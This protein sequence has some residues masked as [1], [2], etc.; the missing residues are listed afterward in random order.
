MQYKG[1]SAYITRTHTYIYTVYI[2]IYIRYTYI[3]MSTGYCI[4]P[5]HFRK[6]SSVQHGYHRGTEANII[7]FSGKK[8]NGDGIQCSPPRAQAFAN[9]SHVIVPNVPNVPAW[10]SGRDGANHQLGVGPKMDKHVVIVIYCVYPSSK[11]I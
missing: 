9:R 2:Y 1:C 8:S 4:F 7:Q 6:H 5:C 10:R 11:L 3:Y